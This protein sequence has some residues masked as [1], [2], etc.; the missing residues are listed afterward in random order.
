MSISQYRKE[1]I[2]VWC[3]YQHTNTQNGK[4]YVGITCQPPNKRWNNGKGYLQ[5]KKFSQAIDKY[6][7]NNF[8]HT[9]IADGL[10]KEDAL[11]LEKKLIANLTLVENGYNNRICGGSG[12]KLALNKEAQLIRNGLRRCSHALPYFKE[13]AEMFDAAEAAGVGSN[14]CDNINIHCENIVRIMT[15]NGN[16]PGYTDYVWLS[17]FLYNLCENIK[18]VNEMYDADAKVKV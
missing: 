10:S 3:V 7:W 11:S 12:A 8:S 13:A 18:A 5:N 2:N 4:A 16:P 9:I 1:G 15:K 6:G 17:L 14:L